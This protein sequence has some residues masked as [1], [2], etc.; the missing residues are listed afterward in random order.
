[1]SSFFQDRLKYLCDGMPKNW[2][3]DKIIF[4]LVLGTTD[5][6]ALQLQ[7]IFEIAKEKGMNGNDGSIT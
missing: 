1:M 7:E 3:K 4:Y 6:N 2:D 5:L